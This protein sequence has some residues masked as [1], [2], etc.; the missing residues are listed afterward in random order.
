MASTWNVN[1]GG[2]AFAETAGS[3]SFERQISFAMLT[4]F[5]LFYLRYW[6]HSGLRKQGLIAWGALLLGGWAILSYVWSESPGSSRGRI[7]GLLTLI[8]VAVGLC[9]RFRSIDIVQWIGLT[10]VVY[11]MIGIACEAA[12]GTFHPGSGDYRFAGTLSPNEEGVNCAL[13]VIASWYLWRRRQGNLFWAAAAFCGLVMCILTKSRTSLIG[14]VVALSVV[15]ILNLSQWRRKAL[16]G[17]TAG[18]LVC[19][20]GWLEWNGIIDLGSAIQMGRETDGAPAESLTGRLPLWAE[21][22]EI[23]GEHPFLGHGFGGFW[24]PERIADISKDQDWGVSAAHCAYLDM[25]IGLGPIGVFLFA[26]T[27]LMAIRRGL[28]VVAGNPEHW[29]PAFFS[30]VLV[31]CLVDGIAD[32]GPVEV[33]AFLC[34]SLIL[35]VVYLGF[36]PSAQ[37]SSLLA[38]NRP[39]HHPVSGTGSECTSFS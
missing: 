6:K 23:P 38:E 22:N 29:E 28:G 32:S 7:L 13:A 35:S 10:T 36:S 17:L 4:L 18:V 26:G 25:K 19:A 12:L 9:A 20:M 24:T 2:K 27:L 34:F 5:G 16:I 39:Q 8:L 11:M 15:Q 30:A 33:S 21:L 37:P 31:F 3:G 14:L 1:R